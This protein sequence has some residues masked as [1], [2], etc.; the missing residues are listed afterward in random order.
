VGII[1]RGELLLCADVS[2]VM[3]RVR[4]APVL[5]VGVTA[6]LDGAAK[7]LQQHSAVRQIERRN[8]HLVA[9]MA[10]GTSDFS[11]L[12]TLLVQAG[13]KLTVFKEDEI[14]LETAFMALTKGITA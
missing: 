5:H 3:R 12:P 4:Q 6:D 14:N 11:E 10:P 2:D 13:Y 9:T 8:G 1:E 7:V